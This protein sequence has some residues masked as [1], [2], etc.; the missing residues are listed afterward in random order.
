MKKCPVCQRR[1]KDTA[2]TCR[3]CNELLVKVSPP[4]KK[5][6]VKYPRKRK[7]KT[8]FSVWQ[9]KLQKIWKKYWYW[10]Y[11]VSIVIA[12]LIVGVQLVSKN[13]DLNKKSDQLTNVKPPNVEIKVSPGTGETDKFVQN[14]SIASKTPDDN[15]S[16]P[17]W[18]NMAVTLWVDGKYSDPNKAIEYLS[19]AIKLQPNYTKTYYNRGLAYYDLGQYQKAIEDFDEAIRLKPDYAHAY[20][21]R[22]T[23]YFNLGNN[24]LACSDFQKACE[25]GVC[26]QLE[27]SKEN[28]ICR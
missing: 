1:F 8:F 14:S 22:G 19:N 28:K 18:N 5:T 15:N 3:Y 24:N 11:I 17:D 20:Y 2:T 12:I 4:K 23:A 21:N 9:V 16:A 10:T 25:L 26:D 7:K 27:K 6:L 13:L